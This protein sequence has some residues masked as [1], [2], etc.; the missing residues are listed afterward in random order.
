MFIP[1]KGLKDWIRKVKDS[2]APKSTVFSIENPTSC[3]RIYPM[4]Q[5]NELIKIAKEDGMH[6]HMDG[7]RIFN[8]CVELKIQPKQLV[9]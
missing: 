7:A 3:G 6:V 1:V 5:F 2:Q 8:A 4:Q 9:K